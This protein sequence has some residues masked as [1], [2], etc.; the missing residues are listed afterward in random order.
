[1]MRVISAATSATTSASWDA[2]AGG[3]G[4][5]AIARQGSRSVVREAFATSPLKLLMPSNHG[6]GAWVFLS[7]YGGGLVD[8][9]HLALDVRVDAGA[10]G[11]MSSQAST[12]VYR[13]PHGT[14]ARVGIR[15]EDEALLVLIPDPV[16]C[17]RDSRYRQVQECDLAATGALV[18]VDWM[19]SGRRASGERWEFMEYSSLIVLRRNGRLLVHDSVTL[20]K[21]DGALSARMGRFD[22]LATIIVAG[23]AVAEQAM[24]VV[25]QTQARPVAARADLLF[26]AALLRGGH[27]SVARIAGR[28]V[29]Q[30]GSAIRQLLGFVPDL[31]GED[32][33][34]RKW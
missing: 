12:K 15:V 31:L 16:A 8:G 5:V 26:S 30:V 1:M 23:D 11:Y 10:V 34:A 24:L 32:P 19:T 29:Q 21:S 6:R 14:S 2:V 25:E 17:F 20:R 3:V 28:S 13:S 7:N 9:D 18:M 27:G 33:W 22:V 4:S